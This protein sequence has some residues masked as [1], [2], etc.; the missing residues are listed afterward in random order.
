MFLLLHRPVCRVKENEFAFFNLHHKTEFVCLRIYQQIKL[1]L[2]QSINLSM[3]FRYPKLFF[4]IC[5]VAIMTCIGW[6]F[7]YAQVNDLTIPAVIADDV[8]VE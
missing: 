4:G 6:V 1:L 2:K 8:F 3:L 7:N 5:G